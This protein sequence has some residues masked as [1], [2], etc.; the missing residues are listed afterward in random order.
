[1]AEFKL[2][3][4]R[5]VWKGT[6]AGT[7]SYTVDDVI[8]N[9]GKSY[10]CVIS[11]T[12]SSLFATDLDENPSYWNLVSDGMEWRGEWAPE[13]Y[14]GA[15]DQVK[16]GANVYVCNTPHTSSTDESPTYYGLE[17]DSANWDIFATSFD[18]KG[19]WATSTKYKL[20]DFVTYGGGTYVC[21]T[22]HISTASAN[23]GLESDSNKWQ[24]F[25]QGIVYLGE[26]NGSSI[27]YKV[28]DLVKY[29][30][31][32]WICTEV[33]V[34][35]AGF[36]DT[37]W[38]MFI[39]GLEFESSWN[40]SAIYQ[41]GDIVTYGGYS[42]I[43]KTNNVNKQPT[44]NAS[45]WDVFTTGFNY[46]GEWQTGSSY[47]IGDVTRLHGYTYLAL[48]D[49]ASEEP[50]N[51][52]YWTQLNSGL[53][54]TNNSQTYTS[55]S[56][57]NIVG[58][59]ANATF[60]VVRSGTVYSVTVNNDGN[61]YGTNDT[62]KILGSSVGGL[63]PIND[64]VITVT[65]QLV[66][67]ILSITWS[68]VSSTWTSGIKYVLGDVVMLGAS[69]YVCV[70]A[71]TSSSGNKPDTDSTAQYW[72]IIAVGAEAATLTAP[73]D[74][75]YY[76][77]NGPTRLP[78]GTEGQI[79]RAKDGFPEWKNYGEI[80]NVVYV[81][82]T[83]NDRPAPSAGLTIDNPWRTVR[84]AC[85]QVE[86]GYLN[87]SAKELLQRNKQ[88]LMKEI[89]AYVDYVYQVTITA[90]DSGTYRFTSSST[91]YLTPGMP[92]SFDG[93]IGGVT[94]GVTYYVKQVV[95]N[96]LFT[97]SQTV[98]G[99]IFLLSDGSGSMIGN[100]VYN[101]EICERD[102]GIIVDSLAFD[103]SH[104]GNE[105]ATAAAK[106]YYT[107]A[108]NE[109]INS[110]LGSQAV[111]TS[112]AYSYLSLLIADVLTNTTPDNDYQA[113]NGNIDVAYQ[114]TD[115]ELVVEPEIIT[116]VQSLISIITDG[117][118]AGTVTAI[119][120]AILPNTSI[121]VKTGTYQEVLPIVLPKN[122]AIVGDELRGTVVQ[123]A[124]ANDLLAN[125]KDKT[126]S[127]L[128][129]IR[130]IVPDLISNTP[131]EA[132][133]G[134][135]ETQIITLPSGNEG[136]IDAAERIFT[137]SDIMYDIV[138]SGE[139]SIPTELLTNPPGYNVSYLAGYGDART[140]IQNNYDFIKADVSQYIINNYSSVWTALG[141]SGQASC[142]RD[143]GYI[144]DAIRY[145]LT[146]GGN[147][148]SLI[149]GSAYYQYYLLTI[150][151]T[152]VDAT[153]AAYGH[154]KTII[155]QVARKLTVTPQAGNTTLQVVT[156]T[157]GNV[158]SATFS[159]SRVQDVVD[160]IENGFGNS[161]IAP[162][163]SWA[164]SVLQSSFN[165]IQ[166]KKVEIQSD[167]VAWVKKFHQ[168]LSFNN[169]VCYRDAGILVDALSYDTVF[170][171][172]FASIKSG[173]S[174][175]RNTA[176]VAVVM[177][178]QKDAELGAINF[179]KYK[180]KT[181]AANG[182]VAQIQ[183]TID[184]I[185][186]FINGG[187]VPRIIWPNP[188]SID[189]ETAG[190]IV[191]LEDNKEFIKAETIA[192]ITLDSSEYNR[193]TCARDVGYF[194]DALRYDLTYGG[195]YATR[196]AAL[197]YYSGTTLQIDI[198]D[199]NATVDAYTWMRQV[200]RDVMSDSPVTP[201]QNNIIQIRAAANQVVGDST[202]LGIV[203][204]LIDD[205]ISTIQNIS[206][207]PAET[208]PS[209]S[210]VSSNLVTY[211]S[212]LQS[213]KTTIKQSVT[214]FIA[215]N[216]PT[217]D[218]NSVTCERDVGYII[219]AVGFDNMFDS[220]YR[221][222]LA[223][224]SYYRA[225]ASLVVSAQK[226]ATVAAYR[227]LKTE[228]L[229]IIGTDA[230]ARPR[231]K[232]LMDII[233]NIIVN[234]DGTTP[235]VAGTTSYKN[236][237]ALIN[238]AEILRANRTF[239]AN[240]ASAWISTTFGAPVTS[241]SSVGNVITTSLK[242]NLSVGDPVMFSVVSPSTVYG[243]VSAGITYYVLTVP[244]STTLT[245]SADQGSTTP[246]Q[247]ST[248]TGEMAVTYGFN[249]TSCQ[250]DMAEFIN[251]LIYDLN[252]TGNY[253]SLRAAQ[254]YN[255]A[256]SGSEKS[257][258]FLVRNGTGVRNQTLNGLY[259]GLTEENDYGTRRPTAGAY[260]SLDPGFGPNDT[261]AWV[262]NK[263]CYV[264]N[265][266]TFGYGCVGCKIDGALHS[267]GNRSIVSNDFTQILSDGIGVWCTGN[268]SLTEL[269]SVFSYYGY[270]GYLAELG[271]KIRATN[272]NSSYGTYGVI[273][274]STDSNEIPITA[275]I[276]NRYNQAQ[277]TNAVTDG[278]DQVL[279][280]EFG[281]AGTNYSNAEYTISGSGFNATAIGDEFR[282]RAVFES[283]I[284]DLNDGNESGGTGYLSVA[285]TAQS[286]ETGSITIAASDT[287][288]SNA[289]VGMRIFLT[290]GTGTGQYAQILTYNNGSKIAKITKE[291]FESINATA[292][293]L[294]NNLI[295][296]ASTATLYV[297]MPIYFTGTTFGGINANTLYYIISANFSSTQFSVSTLSGGSA[298]TLS[299]S[300][301]TMGI[302]AAGWDHVIA[303][304]VSEDS[305][306]LTTTYI[307]EPHLSYIAP[308]S[309]GA[310]TTLSATASW[311]AVSYGAGKFV[312]TSNGTVS[313][314]SSN[315][316]TWANAGTLPSSLAW[317]DIVYNGGE[318]ASA[319]AVVGGL[320][321]FGAVFT[322][323]LGQPNSLGEALSDQV[324]SV[325]IVNS[326]TGY[327]TAP[328]IVFTSASGTGAV[329]TCTVLNG[330]IKTVTVTIPG[331][332]Y[333]TAPTVSAATDRVTEIVVEQWGKNYLTA[334]TVTLTG[335]GS[336]NQATGTAVLT[337]NGVSSITIGNNGGTGYTSTPTVTIV[338]GNAKFIAIPP[339]S[340]GSTKAA[341]TTVSG[342]ESATAWTAST[343]N[344]P[345]GSYQAI[346][347]NGSICVAV[348]GTSSAASSSDGDT[349][350]GRSITVLGS[351]TYTDIAYGNGTFVAVA[352]NGTTSVSSNGVVWSAGGN[353]PTTNSWAIA[354]GNGRFV[355]I[356]SNTKTAAYSIN[357]GE[358][359]IT[360]SSGLPAN[361]AWSTIAYGQ[362]VFTAFAASSQT[363]ATS[364][365]GQTWK[366]GLVSNSILWRSVAFGNPSNT[367]PCFVAVASTTSN[368]G[369]R[370]ICGAKTL[371][372]ARAVGGKITEIRMLEPGS[373]YPSGTI[374]ATNSSTDRITISNSG[375]R[376]TSN[377][378]VTF[379][380][381]AGT[382]LE[383]GVT[384]YVA[385]SAASYFTVSTVPGSPTI[386]Q[387]NT[388]SGLTGTYK[389]GPILTITDPNH[390]IDAA[391]EIRTGDGV[392]ANPTFTNRGT[393]NSTAT[394]SVSGDGYSDLY[395]PSTFIN[396]AGLFSLPLAGS[397][398]EFASIPNIWFKLV[399]VTNVLGGPG[400]YTAQFQINP[401]L[402]VYQAPV[403]GELITTRSKYSQV[404]L[405]GH[406][407]LYIGTGN[408][409]E[410]NYPNVNT[411]TAITA[412]QELA[413]AGGRV[414]F[415]STD[416]DGN[417]NVGN[418]FGVQQSTGTATLNA[419]AFN[420]SGLQ[421][422]QLGS[423]AV[424]AG[425]ALITQ[426]STD[427]YFT[428]NSDNIVP[429]Q[430][431]I[432]SYI[433]SQIGGGQ[434]SLNV[435]TLTSGVIYVAN[436]SISTTDGSEI[437][438]K[439]KMNF[440][441]GIDGA[442]VAL[443]F[444]MQR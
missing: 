415:T 248:S 364:Y 54:W 3:R 117:I 380:N 214:S 72:N 302:R 60:D 162:S 2:G 367:E 391:V 111:Q 203:E 125:D 34:S 311:Q 17:N 32:L 213:A 403:H 11:H 92:I 235:E 211:N 394:A 362:G 28:N 332:G 210:W 224:I 77:P 306:N 266:T 55:V 294:T 263:S 118:D 361:Q 426:F 66:G 368:T 333:L 53:Q 94:A 47:K 439:A 27:R 354:Y 41:I 309:L 112:E 89:S 209:T 342:I 198:N 199:R 314:Y 151:S 327:L 348:G 396:V 370:Y 404:R 293:T 251:A 231:V 90:S 241:T 417:F 253:K 81:G 297:G 107:E 233:I 265:V 217:L 131:I 322:A 148:Q 357:K 385:A 48:L 272:G 152:E 65:G 219:D 35:S 409:T 68:G 116:S 345:S 104:G 45:D 335:G 377:M 141:A 273:A 331:S 91:A 355:A 328:T 330:E 188:P 410:T 84:Y 187:S 228:I 18:W 252:Y 67:N 165:A 427:P 321:G 268:D 202:L 24:V 400:N 61:G 353:L 150:D 390:I 21:R 432:K 236:N 351:G 271:G 383:E 232:K 157:G 73:G 346:T 14:Y 126:T 133:V 183:T 75:V 19:S 347:T 58:T 285:N 207:T 374:T 279:S 97:I 434:S 20:N 284:I 123:P 99:T 130:E 387:L 78:V 242:H 153:V 158:G 255:N 365:D 389:T 375:L 337:N 108:G 256:V 10:I 325:S 31:D 190:G 140:Q 243:G 13:T 182:A 88:F 62:L 178:E 129:R 323:T 147:T 119:P 428:A 59:G 159:Q 128:T 100:L 170:N 206:N 174:Y 431:A 378:P 64:I 239:L 244:S 259:G 221:S 267:G 227:H 212:S 442:P 195:N 411:S 172:N 258:M 161:V 139:G 290:A 407:F 292:T 201:E 416:Q 441:G 301:G 194:V 412:N 381:V 50:P 39:N 181:I 200:I 298:V 305:L 196:Q 70:D 369:A 344:L 397:N 15:G 132:S 264:Q 164:S 433:T 40:N 336:S 143:I 52:T 114:I 71:H 356:C 401:G 163:I 257:D 310:G 155:A 247:L 286:G 12:S 276:N 420:L 262:T 366:V 197:A 395:Q 98:D 168:P 326:G 405:T 299:T 101:E 234:G 340:S 8:V 186:S 363:I 127:A 95:S 280:L 437:N 320:G 240:E 287:Q 185:T 46:R 106:A 169:A 275:T 145:D 230:V 324:K 392:L 160:W 122:T 6:W 113:L 229:E 376:L 291:S 246:V 422:L 171:S 138:S 38:G 423:V 189:A 300:S 36:D 25:N 289:Y 49:N 277:I 184:D 216:Y 386:V 16:Y 51:L 4:I 413:T 180:V 80:T 358:T 350:T 43:A 102:T 69:S 29:G 120:A 146:Y 312:A 154:L 288:L 430:R 398:I 317:T 142:Q 56:G 379:T 191:L 109:Y 402:T 205:F 440:T 124:K 76:G 343:G 419:S 438:V 308:L 93:T 179:L 424:G 436:N 421:S 136:S 406:D 341:Y 245:I 388:T 42:Y 144:L 319:Y 30:A 254:I 303:G 283:R 359:W 156:G 349:W 57:T 425:G 9:G 204:G 316:T 399:S 260:V 444:F 215:E 121:F 82:I 429:T 167:V 193:E 318:G 103:I 338:D 105:H 7:T 74:M 372:R 435:N 218:Y 393:A 5:F 269:V 329:A 274:E 237:L 176:A 86:D 26:W 296:V 261:N 384:Y 238:G 304:K 382:G 418:L 225:A 79:I 408:F 281:N 339:T 443:G 96:N 270:A 33:H 85:K 177:G 307:I 37:K 149:A 23:D 1:M 249:A 173:M 115:S 223:G 166:A 278:V 110:N 22:P 371:A 44:S 313:S 352:S 226:E 220:T 135:L 360:S 134:N 250:R 315:G 83:G 295:T 373:N 175:L 282:D 192:Y 222:I 87:T 414:F 63:S 208:L 137:L 334:P